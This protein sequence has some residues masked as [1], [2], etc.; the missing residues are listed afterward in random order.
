MFEL[1]PP[2]KW[3]QHGDGRNDCRYFDLNGRILARAGGPTWSSQPPEWSAEDVTMRESRFL[4]RFQSLVH[5]QAFVERHFN[6]LLD[7]QERRKT[8]MIMRNH[9]G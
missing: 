3:E 9:D 8:A 2:F 4:G 7:E 6:D 1:A 5:A